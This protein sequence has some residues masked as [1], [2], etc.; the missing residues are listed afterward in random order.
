MIA[1][2]FIGMKELLVIV[3]LTAVIITVLMLLRGR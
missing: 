1:A 2:V 3:V